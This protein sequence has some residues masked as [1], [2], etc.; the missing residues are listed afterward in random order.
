MFST[1]V[2]LK[3]SY[4]PIASLFQQTEDNSV[5]KFG[6]ALSG[7]VQVAERFMIFVDMLVLA[8]F[9]FD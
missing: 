5:D 2:F 3:S 6:L 7:T 1:D 9:L 8:I 4:D